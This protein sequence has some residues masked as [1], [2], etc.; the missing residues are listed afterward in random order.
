MFKLNERKIATEWNQIV[1]SQQGGHQSLFS[2]FNSMIFL[3]IQGFLFFFILYFLILVKNSIIF[4]A[5]THKKVYVKD[6]QVKNG[7]GR[8]NFELTGVLQSDK[9]NEDIVKCLC[10]SF[11]RFFPFAHL[12][13][14]RLN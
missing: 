7:S 8:Q 14:K 6:V 9:N 5:S 11:V 3:A 4:L 12:T 2:S 10:H 13:S 1:N